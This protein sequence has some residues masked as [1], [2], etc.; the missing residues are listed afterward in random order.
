MGANKGKNSIGSP[1]PREGHGED[2]SAGRTP[3]GSESF[4]FLLLS[5]ARQ[6]SWEKIL[7]ENNSLI[8]CR[9]GCHGSVHR[10]FRV[11]IGAS[12]PPAGTRMA[13]VML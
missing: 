7:S 3:T 10:R 2:L 1:R 5:G 9:E 4:K 12:S 13:Q 11:E 6:L 8:Y